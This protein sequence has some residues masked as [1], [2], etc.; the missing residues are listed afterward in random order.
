MRV[1]IKDTSAPE[2]TNDLNLFLPICIKHEFG[3]PVKAIL[4]FGM[5]FE[6]FLLLL[7]ASSQKEA[8]SFP[9]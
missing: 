7:W 1:C 6:N 2:S 9:G 4:K 5:S 3:L 8:P